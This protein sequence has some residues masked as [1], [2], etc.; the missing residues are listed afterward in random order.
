MAKKEEGGM[1]ELVLFGAVLLLVLA[2][3]TTG[4]PKGFG[5]Q[6]NPDGSPRGLRNN[7]PGNI[8]ISTNAWQGKIPVAQNTDGTFEQFTS[9]PYGTRALI[10]LLRTYFTKH[11]LYTVKG[12]LNRF[13]PGSENPIS[14]YVSFVVNRTG[15]SPYQPLTFNKATLRALTSAIADF[16]NGVPGA[17]PGSVFDQAWQMA[18]GGVGAFPLPLSAL[19]YYPSNVPNVLAVA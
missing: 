11:K 16:E 5:P 12:I 3:K 7:N 6:Y 19:P 14:Q 4:A 2:P 9:M 8:K 15:F 17:L 1:F 18:G 13:A 10:V